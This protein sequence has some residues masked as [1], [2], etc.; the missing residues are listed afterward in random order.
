MQKGIME[1]ILAAG[2]L[3]LMKRSSS[4]PLQFWTYTVL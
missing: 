2:D 3:T 4:Y 1:Q